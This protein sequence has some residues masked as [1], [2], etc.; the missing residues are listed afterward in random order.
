MSLYFCDIC[1]C[2]F[3]DSCP[4]GLGWLGLGWVALGC[5]IAIGGWAAE[6]SLVWKM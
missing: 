4:I 5:Y 1:V 6:L 2:Y 3:L